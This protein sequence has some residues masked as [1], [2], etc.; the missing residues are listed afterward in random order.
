MSIYVITNPALQING[1][2]QTPDGGIP[3]HDQEI[4][5]VYLLESASDIGVINQGN[6]LII[7]AAFV[8]SIC[9]PEINVDEGFMLNWWH[10]DEY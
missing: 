9:F 2:S 10:G 7:R 8:V 1:V 4:N 3:R 6:Q 5:I